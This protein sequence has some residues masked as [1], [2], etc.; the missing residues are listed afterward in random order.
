[1]R[2]RFTHY[3]YSWSGRSSVCI[4]GL[5]IYLHKAPPATPQ[6]PKPPQETT[7]SPAPDAERPLG[8]RDGLQQHPSGGRPP[9]RHVAVALL[10]RRGGRRCRHHHL[11]GHHTRR[12]A[13]PGRGVGVLLG[14]LQPGG[15]GAGGWPERRSDSRE[16]MAAATQH[17]AS[18]HAGRSSRSCRD[19]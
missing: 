1:M 8:A 19:S 18:R 5:A 14:V 17:M 9:R 4:R 7:D 16:G 3:C 11:R 10:P 13:W 12:D 2:C 15:G 6:P